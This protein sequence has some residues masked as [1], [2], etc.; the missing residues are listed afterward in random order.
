[1]SFSDREVL[2][3]DACFTGVLADHV[4][5]GFLRQTLTQA[6]PFLFTRRN[7]LAVVR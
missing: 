2:A 6:L 4:P 3:L 1:M 7:S 5:D